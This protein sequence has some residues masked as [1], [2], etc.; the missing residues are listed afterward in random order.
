MGDRPAAKGQ[1]ERWQAVSLSDFFLPSRAGQGTASER[2]RLPQTPPCSTTRAIMIAGR[3]L[4]GYC[5]VEVR[6]HS[7]NTPKARRGILAGDPEGSVFL[8]D[9]AARGEM[10][11]KAGQAGQWARR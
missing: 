10:K 7:S 11:G 4:L 1:L 3:G 8:G 6:G 2:G 5:I 9:P